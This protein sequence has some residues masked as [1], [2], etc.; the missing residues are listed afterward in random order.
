[1]RR[2]GKLR[3]N[4]ER[5]G[6]MTIMRYEVARK[7]LEL[8][9]KHTTYTKAQNSTEKYG[10]TEIPPGSSR[11]F[12]PAPLSRSGKSSLR[13]SLPSIETAL[14]LSG[15]STSV[16]SYNCTVHTSAPRER[17][18][19]GTCSLSFQNEWDRANL[20]KRYTQSCNKNAHGA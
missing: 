1:M 6:S 11:P 10:G 7:V 12:A 19:E 16:S 4:K 13:A 9:M 2:K 17:K 5:V 18:A 15:L 8:C 14:G 20:G 3:L